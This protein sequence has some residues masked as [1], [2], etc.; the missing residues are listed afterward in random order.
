MNFDAKFWEHALAL[1]FMGFGGMT[2]ILSGH[3]E[4]G[5]AMLGMIGG[6]AFKNG[7]AN[8]LSKK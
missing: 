5:I 2:L 6:Y 1:G 4:A 8:Q 7:K 3:T